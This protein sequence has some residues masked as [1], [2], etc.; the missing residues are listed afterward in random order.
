M[1][2]EHLNNA[3]KFMPVQSAKDERDLA[4]FISMLMLLVCMV[5]KMTAP[6]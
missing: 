4:A 5:V 3:F 2:L 6:P 1:K